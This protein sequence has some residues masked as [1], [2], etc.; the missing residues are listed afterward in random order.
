[1]HVGEVL[2]GD[3][4][5]RNGRD[6]ELPFFDQIQQQIERAVEHVHRDAQA[7][8]EESGEDVVIRQRRAT[9]SRAAVAHRLADRHD[10]LGL[11]GAGAL[12]LEPV[13]AQVDQALLVD[14]LEGF[15]GRAL[16]SNQRAS[17]TSWS[18][19]AVSPER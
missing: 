11:E 8:S 13:Q 15:L 3:D 18:W 12:A 10:L 14:V 19:L 16:I 5:Q 9:S 17:S 7:R 4:R 2:V 6:I 1:V